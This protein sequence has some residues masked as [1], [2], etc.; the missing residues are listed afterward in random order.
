[1][2]DELKRKSPAFLFYASDFYSSCADLGRDEVGAYILLLCQQWDRGAL[3]AD[4]ATLRRLARG[5][6]TDTVL[7]KFPTFPDGLRRNARLEKERA[8]HTAYIDAQSRAGKESARVRAISR[9][10]APHSTQPEPNAVPTPLPFRSNDQP[11]GQPSDGATEGQPEG[12]RNGKFPN[13]KPKPEY[14]EPQ[15]QASQC[16]LVPSEAD[17][18]AFC[19]EFPGAPVHGIPPVIPT[20]WALDWMSWRLTPGRPPLV[21][22]RGELLRKFKAEFAERRPLALGSLS[23][24]SS[25]APA[26]KKAGEL[27]AWRVLEEAKAAWKTSPL[28]PDSSAYMGDELMTPRLREKAAELAA[29]AGE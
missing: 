3:P 29:S 2:P 11:N 13:P 19:G 16:P 10:S 4:V 22:W 14:T 5:P 20:P 24:G 17:V 1:M 28:N 15:S 21:D 18:L 8:K 9:G 26:P 27:P 7:E 25:S 23:G 6:V 12:Q